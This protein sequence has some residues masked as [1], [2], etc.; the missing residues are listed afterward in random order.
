MSRYAELAAREPKT[1]RDWTAKWNALSEVTA[2]N[3]TTAVRVA[4]F[5]ERKGITLAALSALGA[6]IATHRQ[7]TCLAFAG[8]NFDGSAVTAIKY[9]PLDGPSDESEA[10]RP[11]VWFRP[12]I[13]GNRDALD[14]FVAE[15]ETDGARLFELVGDHAAILVLP[16]GAL[17]HFKPE[18]AARIPS[19]A[20]VYLCHDA[21]EAGDK[22]ARSAAKVLGSRPVRLRPPAGDWCDWRGT[23]E[24]FVQ[25]VAEA[26]TQAQGS[27]RLIATPL[28]DVE[29]RS[30]EWLEKPLW[31]S[32]AFELLAG[33]KGS[34]K[35]TYLA[36]LA[37]RITR[38]GKNVLF[39]SSEDSAEIDLKPRLVA[40]GADIARC[41][42]IQQS[43]RLPDDID[44]LR[45]LA[46]ELGG[47][48]LLVIDPVANHI[49][50]RNSNTDTEVRHAIAPLNALA[51]ELGCLLIGVRHPGKDRTRGALASILGSTAWVDTPRAVVMVA[52]DDEDPVLRHIQVVAGNRSLNGSAQAFRIEAVDVE[53]LAEPITRAVELGESEKSVD[54]LI[55]AKQG[56]SRVAADLVR[57]AIVQALETGEKSRAYLDEVCADELGVNG[58]TVYKSGLKPLR[59]AGRIRARKGGLNDGWYWRLDAAE[60]PKSPGTP[61]H[62]SS[63]SKP[64]LERTSDFEVGHPSTG[65]FDSDAVGAE[66]PS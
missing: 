63:I 29:M 7:R 48:G 62:P 36:A 12:I 61:H 51:D 42:C 8:W 21:D 60:T 15:G 58:D 14:W 6:R 53:G 44:A 26:K 10:E 20:T 41:F 18:W 38:S 59:E 46:S 16:T 57:D 27:S 65:I 4:A 56:N 1:V 49:G 37:A 64:N 3:G 19:G 45:T 30:I 40:A 5:C 31:Q 24:E 52:V 17:A 11:S 9:R 28:V 22:G 55:G 23:R 54:D 50:D 33:A 47:V 66:R 39:L 2:V 34:G 32:S 13:I 35:G 25:L 43:V